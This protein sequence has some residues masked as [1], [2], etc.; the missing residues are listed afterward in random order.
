MHKTTTMTETERL[1]SVSTIDTDDEATAPPPPPSERDAASS[2]QVAVRIRPLLAMEGDADSC[3]KVLPY[4]DVPCALQIG[5]SSGPRFTFDHVFDPVSRQ[6]HVFDTR[7]APLL[8]S[9]LEGYNATT[10]AYGQTGSGKTYTIMGETASSSHSDVHNNSGIIPRAMVALFE[11]LQSQ[12][13]VE[14]Q[15]KL[16]FLELYGEE[17]RDLLAPHQHHKLTIRDLG[18]D[19]PEVVGATQQVV[20]TAD[21]A[22]LAL[23][24]GML[25]RVTG[26]TAMNETSSRSHAIL[27]LL[28]EQQVVI[29]AAS[30]NGFSVASPSRSTSSG[31]SGK[32]ADDEATLL[33]E[34][35]VVQVKRSKFNFVDLAGSERQK[36][37]Q[38]EGKRLKEGIDINKGLLVLGNVIS[39]LGDPKKRGKTFVPYRD[40][41]LT[42][43]LKGSLGGNHKTLMIACVSPSST[44]M[45][46]SLNC[47]R[48]ANRAKNIQNNAVV[49]VDASSR[50]VAKLQGQVQTLAKELLRSWDGHQT[51]G[52]TFSRDVLAALA[53]GDEDAVLSANPGGMRSA[54]SSPGRPLVT[55]L[56]GDSRL[57]AKV[58]EVQNELNRTRD[59]LRESQSNHDA[60]EEE[61]Y[62]AKAE[63]E[64]YQL[65]LSVLSSKDGGAPP[66]LD[67]AIAAFKDRAVQYEEEIGKLKVA[68]RDA[69]AKASRMDWLKGEA[70]E[71]VAIALAKEALELDRKRLASLQ[72]ASPRKGDLNSMQA[73]GSEGTPLNDGDQVEQNEFAK[74]NTLTK[75]YLGEDHDSDG[76][77]D[78]DDEHEPDQ[79]ASESSALE[80]RHRHIQAD[81]VELTRSIAAKEDLIDQLRLS[82]E[83]YA[84][85]FAALT[86]YCR[87]VL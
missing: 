83:K 73:E 79:D 10:L 32:D 63:K 82:Q 9:C 15:V 6:A 46:E 28:I 2:V 72:A 39:A 61:L 38:S 64:L 42:R 76:D 41:K 29:T 1:A 78:G 44:N 77:G 57:E 80:G 14:F 16:Q 26:A 36:R 4:D 69:Q 58:R 53:A 87:C 11:R 12:P 7:V 49:N 17:I 43:L 34:E 24:H 66:S 86:F 71:E 67:E 8:D 5:G 59:R 31:D 60:A 52:E 13:A 33:E 50:L 30:T 18:D 70:S 62:V 48:Y 45:D 85:R 22:M 40:S 35:Q 65:Q 19:E 81:L 3:I 47:L 21:E 20:Q 56:P 68:F 84:V 51:E 55:P 23:T 27:S 54:A 37:T 25:R 75:K 74:L